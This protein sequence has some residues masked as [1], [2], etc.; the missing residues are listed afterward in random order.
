MKYTKMSFEDIKRSL[1]DYCDITHSR[2]YDKL[3]NDYYEW[4]LKKDM[5]I[6]NNYITSYTT[7]WLKGEQKTL[8]EPYVTFKI[9][10]RQLGLLLAGMD[11]TGI[12]DNH[13]WI[14]FSYVINNTRTAP[15][16]EYIG[17]AKIISMIT[18]EVNRVTI[19][20]SLPSGLHE[21]KLGQQ[22]TVMFIS[23]FTIID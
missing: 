21:M 12:A 23:E 10:K 2:D 17:P 19:K 13:V 9:S 3:Y 5:A 8:S 6:N 15:L 18:S 1:L 4:E 16:I 22:G 20:I 11:T 7:D 14:D